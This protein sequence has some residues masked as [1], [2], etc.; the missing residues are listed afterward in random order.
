MS[1]DMKNHNVINH[2]HFTQQKKSITH[3]AAKLEG[4]RYIGLLAKISRFKI[5]VSGVTKH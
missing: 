2:H 5:F 4:A 1:T 3:I